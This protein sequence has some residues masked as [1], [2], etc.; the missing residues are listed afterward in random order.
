MAAEKGVLRVLSFSYQDSKGHVTERLLT[1]WKETSVYIQGRS[2]ADDL[3][4]TF[5]KDR[6]IEYL[7]GAEYLSFER[8]PPP[9]PYSK[10][11]P[12]SVRGAILFTGFKSEDRIS[13]EKLAAE[14][15]LHVV[16]TPTKNLAF[17]C[18]GYNAG[19]TKV[20]AAVEK[21]AFILSEAQLLAMFQTGVI[22]EFG[23]DKI[24]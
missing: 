5:R 21:G 17:L 10:I 3:Y 19:W 14:N 6:V 24:S 2:E 11:L 8:A 22:S 18:A 1:H 23:A 9:P 7:C 20:Q 13:L 12:A 15:G 16:K 4:R